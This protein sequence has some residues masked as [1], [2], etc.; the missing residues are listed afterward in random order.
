M[1]RRWDNAENQ[2]MEN[3]LTECLCLAEG[4]SLSGQP[5]QD[6]DEEVSL[7]SRIRRGHLESQGDSG[8]MH[9][10]APCPK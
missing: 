9:P 8:A 4:C 2:E 6:K 5:E 3:K 1:K 7:Y 10:D